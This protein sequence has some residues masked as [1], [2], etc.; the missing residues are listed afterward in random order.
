LFIDIDGDIGKGE[1]LHYQNLIIVW[2]PS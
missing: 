1:T 2:S